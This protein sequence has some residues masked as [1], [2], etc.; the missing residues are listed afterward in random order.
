MPIRGPGRPALTYALRGMLALELHVTGPSNDL[1]SG[2][3]GGAV[4]NPAQVL[5]DLVA[6]FH[7]AT[8][9][10]AV[11]RFYDHVRPAS[12]L[13]RAAMARTG[14]ADTELRREA[15]IEH[16]W[17]EPGYS[18]FERTALRPALT[19]N[20]IA[21]GY[22]GPGPMTVIPARARA[23]LSVRLVPDQDPSE[24]AALLEQH[25][26]RLAPPTVHVTVARHAGVPP[27][28]ADRE[29]PARQV[30]LAAYRAGFGAAPVLLRAGGS[31]PAVSMLRDVLG[32]SPLLMGF[33]LPDDGIHGP[34]ERLHL[35]TFWSAI[36]TSIWFLAGL[37]SHP[38]A[39]P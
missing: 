21:G 3:F 26:A 30:A 16:G 10:V 35:P 36:E 9:R 28:L 6:S 8:G 1:H 7:D 5:C 22:T 31:I 27:F 39:A 2:K 18:L 4:H 15:G 37:A 38:G 11:A 14:P 23:K 17:G 29:G 25:V 20:G 19:V 32:V 24:I 33:A 13:E 34:N 12:E